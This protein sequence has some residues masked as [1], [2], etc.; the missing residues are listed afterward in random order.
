MTPEL[1]SKRVTRAIPPLTVVGGKVR[2]RGFTL[3]ELVLVMALLVIVI[4]LIMPSLRGFFQ[5]RTLDSEVRRFVSL[6]HY[7]QSR[8]VSEGT[9][10]L[11]WVDP[12]AGSYGLQQESGYTDGDSK[13]LDYAVGDGLKISVGK[14]GAKTAANAKR[15]GIHFSPDGNVITVTSVTG[16]S[17]QEGTAKPVW[18]VPSANGLNY[19]VQH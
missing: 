14:N 9:P 8:A 19:E 18:I 4:S 12:K 11:L 7:A 2:S 13:A 6:T 3:I 15:S 1:K 16:V 5:G 17:I 10:M